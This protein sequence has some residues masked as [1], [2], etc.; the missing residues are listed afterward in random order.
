M[1][2]DV[3][4]DICRD[5]LPMGPQDKRGTTHDHRIYRPWLADIISWDIMLVNEK[6]FFQLPIEIKLLV[7]VGEDNTKTR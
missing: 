3:P 1:E 7:Q 2:S 4:A 5:K 6:P